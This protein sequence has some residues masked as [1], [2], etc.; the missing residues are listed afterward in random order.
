MI[1]VPVTGP[2]DFKVLTYSKIFLLDKLNEIFIQ[3]TDFHVKTVLM[4]S[5]LYLVYLIIC[6]R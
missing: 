5:K 4:I 6:K 1:S 2:I 3:N